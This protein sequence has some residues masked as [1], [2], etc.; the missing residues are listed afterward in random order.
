[1]RYSPPAAPSHTITVSAA[2]TCRG[3]TSNAQSRS[4]PC[5]QRRTPSTAGLLN[6]G[7]LV[8][9]NHRRAAD[10]SMACASSL[11]SCSVSQ[12]RVQRVNVC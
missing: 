1:M 4:P 5:A 7:V 2:T 10:R 6:P 11:A 8:G 9:L 3:T 12:A